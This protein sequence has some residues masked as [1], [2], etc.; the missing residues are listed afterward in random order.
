MDKDTCQC[1]KPRR[2][3]YV[4]VQ[5]PPKTKRK[6]ISTST[7][8]RMKLRQGDLNLRK[9][10]ERLKPRNLRNNNGNN[11]DESLF[12]PRNIGN[13]KFWQRCGDVELYSSLV[14]MRTGQ[15]FHKQAGMGV[16]GNVVYDLV[17]MYMYHRKTPK[18]SHKGHG[19]GC[20]YT[21]RVVCARKYAYAF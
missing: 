8:K 12:V 3:D 9:L 6:K 1:L 7:E 4:D 16:N 20:L 14:G 2:Q 17:P 15:P 13:T 11:H 5:G 19:K 21:N 10:R 18:K